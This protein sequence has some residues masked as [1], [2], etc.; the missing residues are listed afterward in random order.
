MPITSERTKLKIWALRSFID[1]R[2]A[3]LMHPL[4]QK[5]HPSDRTRYTGFQ[6]ARLEPLKNLLEKLLIYYSMRLDALFPTVKTA[7]LYHRSIKSYSK[8][9]HPFSILKRTI[10][11]ARSALRRK[12]TLGNSSRANMHLLWCFSLHLSASIPMNRE[13]EGVNKDDER[14]MKRLSDENG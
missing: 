5:T 8:N 3:V 14:L 13:Q 1:L 2:L 6:R 9:I 12:R 11:R 10:E 7:G 4:K